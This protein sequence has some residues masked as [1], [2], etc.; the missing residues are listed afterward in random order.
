MVFDV[1]F[2]VFP[3]ALPR[4]CVEDEGGGLQHD[5]NGDVQVSVGHV[6]VQ[7]AG[8][9]LPAERAPEQAGGVDAGPEDEWRGDEACGRGNNTSRSCSGCSP[10]A[11]G[12]RALLTGP[13]RESGSHRVAPWHGAEKTGVP[14]QLCSNL[15]MVFKP[16]GPLFS[17]LQNGDHI[18][19]AATAW[20]TDPVNP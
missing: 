8:A 1:A 13:R 4:G 5:G 20:K 7:D 6:V 10:P 14:P 15:C 11:R 19:P 18:A 16:P 9:L 2:I 17:H 12:H 3:Q